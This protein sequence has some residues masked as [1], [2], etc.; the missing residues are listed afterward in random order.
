MGPL[1]LFIMGLPRTP[2]PSLNM[3]RFANRYDPFSRKDAEPLFA[4]VRAPCEN[5]EFKI[6][7][8]LLENVGG[9]LQPLKGT[10]A[11]TYA[12]SLDYL[13]DG[14]R[15][16]MAPGQK[17]RRVCGLRHIPSYNCCYQTLDARTCGLPHTRLRV[18]IILIRLDMFEAAAE[19]ELQRLVNQ[20]KMRP[21]TPCPLQ[22]FLL[23]EIPTP[24]EHKAKQAR[25][26]RGGNATSATC[27]AK[28]QTF[29]KK[30][31]IP[32]LGSSRARPSATSTQRELL[33]QL[34]YRKQ[35][36]SNAA[37][38]LMLRKFGHIPDDLSVN[39]D[40]SIS[41]MPWGSGTTR[42]KHKTQKKH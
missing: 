24:A 26:S 13:L 40:Q 5:E 31:G 4:L 33:E 17:R 18:F 35:E 23:D 3:D 25:N 27:M 37:F 39:A 32:P 12:T 9:I 36:V 38:N 22:S 7:V 19:F 1:D 15:G 28:F 20:I 2:Y 10:T 14:S 6:R 8:V 41:R 21:L 29:R 30:H 34:T 11:K 16:P 42:H